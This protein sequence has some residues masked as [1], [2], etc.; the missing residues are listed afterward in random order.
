[1][2][3]TEIIPVSEFTQLLTL[4]T[5]GNMMLM[6]C[7]L[8]HT[9]SNGHQAEEVFVKISKSC[10]SN[11]LIISYGSPAYITPP[12]LN[13]GPDLPAISLLIVT[14]VRC[15]LWLLLSLSMIYGIR[16]IAW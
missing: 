16:S 13:H 15:N 8:N 9:D 1:M 12:N 6:H 14:E 3:G 7:W 11:V 5:D 4:V 10:W 2:D